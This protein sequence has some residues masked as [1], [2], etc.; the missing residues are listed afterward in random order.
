VDIRC[1][2]QKC[3][4][5]YKENEKAGC[6]ESILKKMNIFSSINVLKFDL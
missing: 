2:F 1:P 4:A 3:K 6:P 5:N